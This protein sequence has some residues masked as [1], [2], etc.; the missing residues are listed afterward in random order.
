MKINYL[1]LI[2]TTLLLC[3]VTTSLKA[4]STL[5][6]KQY[7]QEAAERLMKSISPNTG[8]NAS[9]EVYEAEWD[10]NN[11]RYIIEMEATWRAGRCGLCNEE[12]FVV[13]GILK[14]GKN[15]DNP[16]FKETY[17]NSAV[18]GAWSDK[19]VGAIFAGLATL[20]AASSN[21]SS[22]GSY[23]SGSGAETGYVYIRNAESKTMCLS[24]SCDGYSYSSYSL[25]S[26][27]RDS[28]RCGGNTVH[29]RVI[30]YTNG[31][32]CCRV[33]YKLNPNSSYKIS[34]NYDKGRYDVYYD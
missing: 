7:A 10:G 20:A 22:S 8:K 9:A 24:L 30:T 25:S 4:Q 6:A 33:E 29:I 28:Y 16:S 17:K 14:V 26:Y 11:E 2:L 19:Q 18:Q 27:S 1:S 15:G 23:S 3:C 21:S 31:Y 13:R 34:Y 32:E 12:D 5:M